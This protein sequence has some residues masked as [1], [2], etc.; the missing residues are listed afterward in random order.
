MTES[1]QSGRG[2]DRLS[3]GFTC[4]QRSTQQWRLRLVGSKVVRGQT[5]IFPQKVFPQKPS[6][7]VSPSSPIP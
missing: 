2:D 4:E 6:F 1:R 7:I 3:A 5:K